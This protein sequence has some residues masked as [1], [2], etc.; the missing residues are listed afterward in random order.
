MPSITCAIL[1]N[2]HN[3]HDR[4]GAFVHCA[5]ANMFYLPTAAI[6]DEECQKGADA[7]RAQVGA[8]VSI[9]TANARNGSAFSLSGVTNCQLP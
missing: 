7:A 8:N 1:P 2:V 6:S 5:Q 9:I 3:T 4:D